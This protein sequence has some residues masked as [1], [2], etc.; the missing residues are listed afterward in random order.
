MKYKWKRKHGDVW[1]CCSLWAGEVRI[2]A[3]SRLPYAKSEG[4]Y[5]FNFY[6]PGVPDFYNDDTEK[7][8]EDA[9]IYADGWFARCEK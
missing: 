2:G 7:L 9:L 1:E 4:Q 8:K 5:V 3:Y 6:L